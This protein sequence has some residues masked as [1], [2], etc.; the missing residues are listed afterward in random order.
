MIKFNE[1]EMNLFNKIYNI[2]LS[3]YNGECVFNFGNYKFAVE[4]LDFS[5]ESN[6]FQ[7][8]TFGQI[9]ELPYVFKFENIHI[10]VIS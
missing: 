1:N 2:F 3:P 7:L 6:N 8:K 9:R 5:E 4:L 10:F